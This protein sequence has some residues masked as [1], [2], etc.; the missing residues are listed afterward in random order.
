MGPTARGERCL[1]AS[2][3]L[4]SATQGLPGASWQH[5]AKNNK[6]GQSIVLASI[7]QIMNGAIQLQLEAQ[8]EFRLDSPCRPLKMHTLRGEPGVKLHLRFVGQTT[9]Q[10]QLAQPLVTVILS[11]TSSS[12]DGPAIIYDG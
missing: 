6:A 9:L 12:S 1:A 10:H 2:D 3:A 4:V 8:A 11:N 5:K 7:S